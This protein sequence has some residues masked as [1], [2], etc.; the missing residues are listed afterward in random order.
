M[1]L[2]FSSLQLCHLLEADLDLSFNRKPTIEQRRAP[3]RFEHRWPKDASAN[4]ED[5]QGENGQDNTK[6]SEVEQ[7]LKIGYPEFRSA[8][9][10]HFPQ[11]LTKGLGT[12]R[13]ANSTFQV[14]MSPST[15]SG[16]SVERV[17]RGYMRL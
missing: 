5:D 11:H 10:P 6:Q 4:L 17:P 7:G 9:W 2:K 12:S 16:F 1:T 13:S 15:R 8:Y 14:L 3:R